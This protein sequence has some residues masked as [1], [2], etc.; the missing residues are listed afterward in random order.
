MEQAGL[1]GDDGQHDCFC[2]TGVDWGHGTHTDSEVSS[3]H[4]MSHTGPT[5]IGGMRTELMQFTPTHSKDH[6]FFSRSSERG[7]YDDEL[8]NPTGLPSGERQTS[9]LARSLLSIPIP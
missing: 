4:E 5:A 7:P 1:D 2:D 3:H 6:L 9:Q 8:R